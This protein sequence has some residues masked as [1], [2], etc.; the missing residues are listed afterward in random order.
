MSVCLKT[1]PF[2]MILDI[3]MVGVTPLFVIRS[4]ISE[5]QSKSKSIQKLPIL[6][7]DSYSTVEY[8]ILNSWL[9]MVYAIPN[10]FRD[11]WWFPPQKKIGVPLVIIHLRLGFFPNK[12]HP[13]LGIPI[14]GTP[15]IQ[16]QT[17]E[18]LLQ[19]A[20]AMPCKAQKRLAASNSGWPQRAQEVVMNA[21]EP[22]R[23]YGRLWESCGKLW[24]NYG[25]PYG[26]L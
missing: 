19:V 21:D 16:F 8:H 3:C 15:H 20:F 26:K 11:I 17:S 22:P 23:N 5:N 2:I 24:E 9:G 14:Y 1:W 13:F 4:Q 25:K 10:S 12:N 6:S 18:S 7:F